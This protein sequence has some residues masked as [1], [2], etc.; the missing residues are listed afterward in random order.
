MADTSQSAGLKT[1]NVFLDTEVYRQYGHNLNAKVLQS[2]LRQIQE[3]VCTL[4]ITDITQAEIERQIGELAAEVA[5]TVNKG[6]KE[7]RRWQSRLTWPGGAPKLGEDIK[8]EALA[9]AAVQSFSTALI[10]D[11]KPTRHDALR[12]PTKKIFD[13]YFRRNPPFDKNDSKEF[14]DAFVIA[15][16]DHW[17]QQRNEKMYVVTR[18]GAM[19]RAAENTKTLLPLSSLD[20]LLEIIVEAQDPEI[21]KRVEKILE[22]KTWSDV[23]DRIREE[24]P[25]LGT[26]YSGS[27]NDGEIIDH[28][29]GNGSMELADFH[30]ISVSNE[31]IEVVVK[32]K[33]PIGF[34]LQYEDLTYAIHDSEDD[35]YYGGETET[36]K[37]EVEV[38]ISAFVVID[39]ANNEI[40]DVDILTRDLHLEEPYEDYG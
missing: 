18:D 34:E 9:K 39:A 21:L 6:N 14:P 15:A 33:V 20:E 10:I 27:L 16:L 24:I 40:T 25:G 8:A 12:V 17:C 32:L 30:V 3:H 2:F 37:L 5:S 11:W 19:K 13:S 36:I 38:T 29:S 22:S 23:E 4:H 35:T 26:V 1:Q 28:W 31:S 7:L